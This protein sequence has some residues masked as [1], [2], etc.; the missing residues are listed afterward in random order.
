MKDVMALYVCSGGVK[1]RK[2]ERK[3]AVVEHTRRRNG[4]SRHRSVRSPGY[5]RFGV[6]CFGTRSHTFRFDLGEGTEGAF[7]GGRIIRGDGE[8]TGARCVLIGVFFR[9]VYRDLVALFLF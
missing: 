5:R 6:L 2:K 1:E 9:R 3:K 4:G 8:S 7:G